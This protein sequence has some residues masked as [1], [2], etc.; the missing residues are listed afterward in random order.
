MSVNIR[1]RAGEM[2]KAMWENLE[3]RDVHRVKVSLGDLLN[4]KLS[5]LQGRQTAI[6]TI[7]VSSEKP[8][9]KTCMQISWR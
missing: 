2:V 5:L 8:E 6:C 7:Y 1:S 9:A 4:R 3:W